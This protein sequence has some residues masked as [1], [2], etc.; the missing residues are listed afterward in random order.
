MRR[1]LS[2][3]LLAIGLVVVPLAVSAPAVANATGVIS[4]S[5]TSYVLKVTNTGDQPIRCMRFTPGSGVT[6]TGF[7]APAG[8][9]GGNNAQFFFAVANPSLAPGASASFAFTTAAAYPANAG[10]ELRVSPDCVT[11][12]S[13]RA[14]G[15]GGGG[16]DGGKPCACQTLSVKL[17]G[18]IINKVRIAP[19][20][21]DF[22][23]GFSWSM[24]CTKG[25]GTCKGTIKFSPPEILAGE[26][27]KPKQNLFINI[28]KKTFI[29]QAN[30]GKN[31]TGKFQAKM[32]SRD[33]LK[34]L[35]GRTMAYTIKTKCG[36]T[37]KTIKVMVSVNQN[38]K[39]RIKK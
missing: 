33:Q 39:L 9:Q 19:D 12:V 24:K 16:D 10:G 21:Q 27:P 34:E 22:G 23:V 29:C 31:K 36:A 28:G 20:D 17:D 25:K 6:L 3:V 5:G 32:L 26:L 8:W 4:G 30:C 13:I 38:G 18:T 2:P 37:T 7:T 15:P 1:L 14:T 11:D 35:F